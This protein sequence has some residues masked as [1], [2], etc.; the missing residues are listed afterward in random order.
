MQGNTTQQKGTHK[1]TSSV[2]SEYPSPLSAILSLDNLGSERER[3]ILEELLKETKISADVQVHDNNKCDI[4]RTTGISNLHAFTH[5][6]I[7]AYMY[8]EV[9]DI[10]HVCIF[11][12]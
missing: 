12:Y 10:Y 1:V 3:E 2:S 5:S 8:K 7:C 11:L 6:G 4:S 9:V